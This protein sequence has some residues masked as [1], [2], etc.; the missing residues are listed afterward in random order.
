MDLPYDIS[1]EKGI[2]CSLIL[3]P[4]F[5]FEHNTL[6]DSHFF[7]KQNGALFWAIRN[8][9]EKGI[10]KIDERNLMVQLNSDLAISKLIGDNVDDQIEEVVDNAPLIARTSV[11][12]YKALV[13]RVVGLGFKR[14]LYKKI[15]VIENKCLT[16]STNDITSLH[17]EVM[18]IMDN[19]A[20]NFITDE[21]VQNFSDKIDKIWNSVIDSRNPDGTFGIPSRWNILR[22]YF[23]YQSGELTLIAARRKNGK[24]V[25]AMNECVHLLKSGL[26]VVYFDTEMQDELFTTR[27]LSHITGIPEDNIKSGNYGKEED[28]ILLDAR[29]WL[30]KQKLVHEYN[31]RWTKEAIITKCKILH[32][33]GRLDF[34][35]YDYIKDTSGKNTSS[36]DIYNELGNW[37]DSIKNGIC[38]ALKIPGLTFAQLNR[39]MKIADSDKIERYVTT[40]CTWRKKTSEEIEKDGKECGNYCLKVDFNRIGNSHEEDA[41]DDYI[42]MLFRGSILTIDVCKKQHERKDKPFE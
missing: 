17:S 31:P 9:V 6:K 32:N 3:Y 20:I 33:Q 5:I 16:D 35:I 23:T 37:C 36:S 30:K 2:I 34:F 29:Q 27:M 38:G 28:K 25:I 8:L 13:N 26:A 40:G 11:E 22:N 7:D 15:K 21:A 12:E 18:N 39:E 1:A 4:N 42:D 41:E 24:S 14:E 10:M 19:M